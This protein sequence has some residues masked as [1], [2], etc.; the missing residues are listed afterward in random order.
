[1]F[2]I[3]DRGP[4]RH[5]LTLLLA[6][7]LPFVPAC[8]DDPTG[9]SIVGALEPFQEMARTAECAENRNR[10][11]LI[12]CEMVFWDSAGECADAGYARILYGRTVDEIL[13]FHHDSIGGP[14]E[15]CPDEEFREMFE[16]ILENL[17]EPDL[18]LGPEHTVD[19]I[20]F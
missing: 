18:G 17:D 14:Q 11:Y 2:E 4:C 1:M 15:G 8:G 6:L 7:S 9:P 3:P 10:L 19:P 20:P 12:D 16:T 5:L 13:C